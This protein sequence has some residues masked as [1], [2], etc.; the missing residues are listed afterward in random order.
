MLRKKH[1]C[2][3]DKIIIKHPDIKNGISGATNSLLEKER[4]AGKD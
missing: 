3:K 2:R 4:S 1:G